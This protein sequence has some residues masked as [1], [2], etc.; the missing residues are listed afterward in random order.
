MPQP[1]TPVYL[2][3]SAGRTDLKAVAADAEGACRLLEI[4]KAIQRPL[5]EWM[6]ENPQRWTVA[7]PEDVAA[8]DESQAVKGRQSFDPTEFPPLAV[9]QSALATDPAGRWLLLAPKLGRMVGAMAELARSGKIALRGAL[10]LYTHRER[11]HAKAKEEPVAVGLALA[12]WLAESLGLQAVALTTEETPPPLDAVAYYAF[13][14]G[15]EDLEGPDNSLNPIACARLEHLLARLARAQPGLWAFV[16]ALGGLPPY[17]PFLHALAELHFQQRWRPVEDTEQAAAEIVPAPHVFATATG[18]AQA[19]ANALRLLRQWDIHG[20]L[21]ALAHLGAGSGYAALKILDQTLA[22]RGGRE[23]SGDAAFDAALGRLLENPLGWKERSQGPRGV[24]ETHPAPL[25][26]ILSGLRAECSLREG[27]VAE[28]LNWTY[29]FYNAMLLDL[30]E[31]LARERF[32]HPGG[33]QFLRIKDRMLHFSAPPNIPQGLYG[34]QDVWFKNAHKSPNGVWI[35]DGFPFNQPQEAFAPMQVLLP[36]AQVWA[37]AYRGAQQC[38]KL[39]NQNTHAILDAAKIKQARAKLEQAGVWSLDKP[40]VVGAA[41]IQAC[42][43]HFYGPGQGAALS[44]R[45]EAVHAA[46]INAVLDG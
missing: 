27:R 22:G 33:A 10:V 43:A 42:L 21:A 9:E 26:L 35:N 40:T 37:E 32:S 46:A 4:D 36:D 5:H 45:I 14:T 23:K 44:Q 28:A 1:P 38:K 17:K 11:G 30:L 6:L 34:E 29:T 18:Q 3:V 31:S 7:A 8:L 25:R 19:R 13:L 15:R 20:A 39:R 41:S 16:S 12:R 2:I 24:T